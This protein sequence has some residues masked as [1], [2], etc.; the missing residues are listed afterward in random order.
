MNDNKARLFISYSHRGNGPEWKAKLVR[1]LRVFEEQH[2]LDVWQDGK[3]RVS[4]YWHDDIQ[5]S[6]SDARLAVVLITPEAL[7]SEY[8]LHTEFPFLRG[9]R[10]ISQ[11]VARVSPPADSVHD[12]KDST[13][14]TLSWTLTAATKE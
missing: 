2:L 13:G 7:E 14:S 5:Q 1:H 10:L 9:R 3:I 11:T 8:V 12:P 6:M 4:S